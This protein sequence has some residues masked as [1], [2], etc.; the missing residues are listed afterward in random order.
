M[1]INGHT[2]KDVDK[3]VIAVAPLPRLTFS[4]TFILVNITFSNIYQFRLFDVLSTSS[5]N[6]LSV[7]SLVLGQLL[8]LPLKLVP[9]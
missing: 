6:F 7:T 9:V 1:Y 2:N 5:H 3:S 8:P 4:D